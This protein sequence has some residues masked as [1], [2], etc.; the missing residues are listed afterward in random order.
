MLRSEE[1]GVV[2]EVRLL[3]WTVTRATCSARKPAGFA[4]CSRCRLR[5]S[6]DQCW[7][8]DPRAENRKSSELRVS[9]SEVRAP[10]LDAIDLPDDGGK[11]DD[12]D[13]AVR[14]HVGA[15]TLPTLRTHLR[16][17][18]QTNATDCLAR[19]LRASSARRDSTG[20]GVV[21][22]YALCDVRYALCGDEV[23]VLLTRSR[24][25]EHTHTQQLLLLLAP[26]ARTSWSSPDLAP[27]KPASSPHRGSTAGFGS[28][29]TRSDALHLGASQ[30]IAELSDVH[31]LQ[32]PG[33]PESAKDPK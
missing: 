6:A 28:P 3:Q 24:F 30:C 22:R 26:R 2:E 19:A 33:P 15:L 12:N 23:D 5:V 16:C 7:T 29:P 25:F 21:M 10:A 32:S 18:E 11:S 13:V 27:R 9:S 31:D 4:T 17:R 8:K 20:A 14:L 1:S